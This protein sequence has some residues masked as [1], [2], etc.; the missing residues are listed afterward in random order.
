MLDIVFHVFGIISVLTVASVIL[1]VI[2]GS[3]THPQTGG[4]MVVS[5]P[6]SV[7]YVIWLL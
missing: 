6:V 3:K 7:L 2:A 4:V 1:A 5:V